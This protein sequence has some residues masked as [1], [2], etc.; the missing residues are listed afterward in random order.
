VQLVLLSA[1]CMVTASCAT[2]PHDINSA[3]ATPARPT[4]PTTPP[5]PASPAAPAAQESGAPLGD[6]VLD[7]AALRAEG[8]SKTSAVAHLDACGERALDR[9]AQ[10][11]QHTWQYPTGSKLTQV[12]AAMPKGQPPA[13][14]RC[15]TPLDLPPQ[16][17]VDSL[18]AWCDHGCA[19][20]L[21]KG[22]TVSLVSVRASTKAKSAEAIKRLT[23]FAAA[24][25]TPR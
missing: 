5:R 14:S 12:V 7:E 3:P 17:T 9:A 11:D 6:A 16:P 22:G 10:T 1:V 18:V 20:L 15:G 21:G 23:P 25:L 13:P 24:K 8:V 4:Q 19:V 2:E